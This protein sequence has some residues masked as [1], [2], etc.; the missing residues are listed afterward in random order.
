MAIMK[1][2]KLESLLQD[3]AEFGQPKIL[4]E[5]YPTRPHIAACMLHTIGRVPTPLLPF[6]SSGVPWGRGSMCWKIRLMQK[7][8]WVQNM[9]R[10]KR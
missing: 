1:L 5:Q 7:S 9:E 4:L 2:K 3:V 10:E 8:F 6:I